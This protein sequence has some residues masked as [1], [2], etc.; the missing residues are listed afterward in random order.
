MPV[1][2][3]VPAATTISR[4]SFHRTDC[5]RIVQRRP[6]SCVCLN[7]VPSREP[8]PPASPTLGENMR[9]AGTHLELNPML[10]G[11]KGTSHQVYGPAS[12][13]PLK[14]LPPHR[15]MQAQTPNT[16]AAVP[17]VEP[18]PEHPCFTCSH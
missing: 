5:L 1:A 7:P 12:T 3:T 15:A 11:S 6:S 18:E 9:H 4:F 17:I 14:R 13:T 8:E 16:T 2:N 10:K